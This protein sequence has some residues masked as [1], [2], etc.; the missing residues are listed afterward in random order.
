VFWASDLGSRLDAVFGIA[1]A[2][3]TLIQRGEIGP[4]VRAVTEIAR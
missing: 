3:A 4:S 2:V 1:K